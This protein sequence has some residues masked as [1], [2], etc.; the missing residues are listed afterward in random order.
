MSNEYVVFTETNAR[1]LKNPKS[2]DKITESYIIL[3]NPRKLLVSYIPLHY[4]KADIKTNEVL[5]MNADERLKRDEQ[6]KT[7]GFINYIYKKDPIP[8][9]IIK[10]KSTILPIVPTVEKVVINPPLPVCVPDLA[11]VPLVKEKV[12]EEDMAKTKM[13][14][15][16]KEEKKKPWWK[17]WGK[18]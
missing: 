1:I 11:I 14:S 15:K 18:K 9:P 8:A 16:I 17:F 10:I 6:I 5:P 2:L 3:K 4:W 12:N 7:L 13:S